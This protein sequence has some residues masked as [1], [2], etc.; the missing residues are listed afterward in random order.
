MP[1][2]HSPLDLAQPRVLQPLA[3]ETGLEQA[4]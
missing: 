1:R 4:Q 2:K 3:D